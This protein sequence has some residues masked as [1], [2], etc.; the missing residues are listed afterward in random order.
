MQQSASLVILNVTKWNEE[1]VSHLKPQI[2]RYAQNDILKTFRITTLIC[3]LN[4]VYEMMGF[5]IKH[6]LHTYTSE[7]R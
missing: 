2:L 3:I 5:T 4:G 7:R 6:V 1:S